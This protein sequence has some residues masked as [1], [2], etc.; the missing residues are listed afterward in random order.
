MDFKD[1]DPYFQTPGFKSRH[2]SL[3][4]WKADH[5]KEVAASRAVFGA[6]S[7]DDATE[8]TVDEFITAIATDTIPGDN[9][10]SDKT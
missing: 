1:R 10:A 7:A 3:Q 4:A 2:A 9:V 6:S 8:M 5:K